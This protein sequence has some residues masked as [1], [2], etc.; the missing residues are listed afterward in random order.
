MVGYPIIDIASGRSMA[1][2]GAPRRAAPS[3][4]SRSAL[5]KSAPR[6]ALRESVAPRPTLAG[7][8]TRA[9][10]RRPNMRQ[11]HRAHGRLER[12][13]REKEQPAASS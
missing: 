13:E 8:H 4:A 7:Q 10:S 9:P 6:G 3:K 11:T 1:P 5:K 12:W 2:H